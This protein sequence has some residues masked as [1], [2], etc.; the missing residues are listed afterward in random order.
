MPPE[1]TSELD[2][3]MD[4]PEHREMNTSQVLLVR[5][6]LTVSR[7]HLGKLMENLAQQKIRG[8][9]VFRGEA[10]IGTTAIPEGAS[11]AS[12]KDPPLVLEFFDDD[13]GV[14][15]TLR[16]IRALVAPRHVVMWP[17]RLDEPK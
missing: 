2:A 11:L 9:T 1:M 8:V 14:S 12:P 7:A 10:G 17:V 15:E 4:L 3:A 6:Y 5:V 16:V 13:K